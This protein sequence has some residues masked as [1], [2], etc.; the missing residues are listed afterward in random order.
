MYGVPTAWRHIADAN[1]AVLPSVI[2]LPPGV[3]LTIPPLPTG[4]I[5]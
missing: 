1:S 4:A 5:V 2:D 3:M